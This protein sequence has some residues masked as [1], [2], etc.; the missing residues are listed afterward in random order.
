MKNAYGFRGSI[1]LGRCAYQFFDHIGPHFRP[2]CLE[3]ILYGIWL[4]SSDDTI[5]ALGI[6]DS[7]Q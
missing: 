1:I 5:L 6:F 4:A 2:G 7:N 3:L